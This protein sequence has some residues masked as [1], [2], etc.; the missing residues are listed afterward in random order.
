MRKDSWSDCGL[1]G[2]EI[3]KITRCH[4]PEECGLNSRNRQN[5][6]S[7]RIV[8]ELN[9]AHSKNC[10]N[11]FF[12]YIHC[13]SK[14]SRF[15]SQQVCLPYLVFQTHE[16]RVIWE[17][18]LDMMWAKIKMYFFIVIPVKQPIRRD[19]S[20]YVTCWLLV[21]VAHLRRSDR[22]VS[23]NGGIVIGRVT[24]KHPQKTLC[25]FNDQEAH[26]DC[27]EVQPG[28]RCEKLPPELPHDQWLTIQNGK[29]TSQNYLNW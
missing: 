5:V 19:D 23:S 24:P 10:F 26:M 12:P 18:W 13:K 20:A 15:Y 2:C 17:L 3:D 8:P 9:W 21:P 14:C 7:H 16:Q 4:N 6:R 11:S 1:L 27:T 22:W 25:Q 28:C 29:Q